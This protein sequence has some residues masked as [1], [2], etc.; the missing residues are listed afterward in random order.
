MALL[1]RWR[2]WAPLGPG[3]I[4]GEGPVQGPSITG[5]RNFRYDAEIPNVLFW[6]PLA[7]KSLSAEG[8]LAARSSS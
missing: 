6:P 2:S 4:T 7:A 8:R 1:C 3:P 5:E